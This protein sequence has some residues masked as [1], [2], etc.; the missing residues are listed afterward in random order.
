M[1]KDTISNSKVYLGIHP[2][3]DKALES[4]AKEEYLQWNT[5]RHDIRKD[6]IF[7]LIQE[8]QTRD[9][10]RIEAH[11]KYIDIQVVIDGNERINYAERSALQADGDFD[12]DSDVGFFVEEGDPVFLKKGDFAVFF[13]GDGHAPGMRAGEKPVQVRKAVY[14]IH[15]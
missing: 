7:C 1:I 13:P 4:I 12:T 8:Y 10:G 5:G 9:E 14:K 15:I 11:D 6:E 2:G 3:I